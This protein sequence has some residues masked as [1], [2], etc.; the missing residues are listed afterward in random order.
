MPKTNVDTVKVT[1]YIEKARKI[2]DG[3]KFD[4]LEDLRN[5]NEYALKRLLRIMINEESLMEDTVNYGKTNVNVQLFTVFDRLIS[6]QLLLMNM[7]NPE[8]KKDMIENVGKVFDL[9]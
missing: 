4:N 5:I 2:V 8:E 7:L 3:F 1:N 6:K 9:E